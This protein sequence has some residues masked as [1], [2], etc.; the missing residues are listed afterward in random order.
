MTSVGRK[1]EGECSEVGLQR[2]VKN[3]FRSWG[4]LVRSC[5]VTLGKWDTSEGY[6]NQK[7]NDA[8]WFTLWKCQTEMSKRARCVIDINAADSTMSNTAWET[9]KGSVYSSILCLNLQSFRTLPKIS[10]LPESLEIKTK[11]L[12]IQW[13]WTYLEPMDW[14]RGRLLHLPVWKTPWWCVNH[15]N[16]P[17]PRH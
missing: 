2:Q 16:S 6:S 14:N 10:V 9:G 1:Q 4:G 13:H 12:T 3:A 11:F 17:M 15:N 7:H 5:N 8:S